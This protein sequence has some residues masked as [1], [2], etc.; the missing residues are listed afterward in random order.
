MHNRIV[1]KKWFG[2]LCNNIVQLCHAIYLAESTCSYLEVLPHPGLLETH[3]FDFTNGQPIQ[4]LISRVFYWMEEDEDLFGVKKLDWNVRRN[5]LKRYIRPMLPE[6][7]FPETSQDG[8]TIYIR[9]GDIFKPTPAIKVLKKAPNPVEGLRRVLYG[10]RGICPEFVQPPLAFYKRVIESQPWSRIVL[11]AEDTAN[12]NIRALLKTYNDIEFQ[13]R[14]LES[15]ITALLSAQNLVIS[16]GTFGITWALLS[17]HIQSLYCPLLPIKT[18]GQLYP[19]DIK[20]LSVYPF[21][22]QNYI[23]I[24]QWRSTARQK[25][26]MLRYK[27][28]NILAIN[29]SPD[30]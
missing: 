16:Y 19:G 13:R 23:P 6:R 1:I 17:N 21:E 5:L 28:S 2:R 8:L 10:K 7:L 9:S 25:R 22:F 11:I 24:G 15:D 20:N 27:G 26:L 18:Y 14:N 30:N 29:A 12:P 3:D 4:D